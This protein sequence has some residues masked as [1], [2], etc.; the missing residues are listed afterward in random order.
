[1]GKEVRETSMLD[2]NS[3]GEQKRILARRTIGYSSRNV[4]G[5]LQEWVNVEAGKLSTDIIYPSRLTWLHAYPKALRI[6]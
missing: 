6:F 4:G 2:L 1:M 3:T 5:G